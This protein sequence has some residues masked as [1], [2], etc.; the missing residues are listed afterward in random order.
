MYRFICKTLNLN[1]ELED[2]VEI[3]NN[4]QVNIAYYGNCLYY[5]AKI[6]K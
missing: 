5:S 3:E 1:V 4:K 2:A 6:M